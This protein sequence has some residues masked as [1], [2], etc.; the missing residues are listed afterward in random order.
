M[1]KLGGRAHFRH[2]FDGQR[3]ASAKMNFDGFGQEKVKK[4]KSGLVHVHP[5]LSSQIFSDILVW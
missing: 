5:P 3:I 4:I 2:T 1:E